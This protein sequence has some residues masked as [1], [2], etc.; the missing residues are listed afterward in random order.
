MSA[1]VKTCLWFDGQG[2]QA[3]EFYVSLLPNSRIESVFRPSPE[4]PAL[5]VEF[6]LAGT[7]YQALNGGPLYQ[8]NEATSLV[9]VTEDQAETDQLW[10]ALT[11]DGG[12]ESRCGWLVDRFGVS[13]QI[14][15]KRLLQLLSDSDRDAAGRAMQAMLQMNKIEIAALEAVHADAAART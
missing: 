9:V 4:G 1:K 2:E 13:W 7:P 14:V 11:A 8:L 12:N 10:G 3:A 5:V 6:V 15:P